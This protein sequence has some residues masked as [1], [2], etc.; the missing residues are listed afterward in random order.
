M[1]IIN[2][3]LIMKLKNAYL[4]FIQTRNEIAEV[5]TKELSINFETALD[6]IE[7]V[8]DEESFLWTQEEKNKTIEKAS[9][10]V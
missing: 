3:L 7:R 4:P 2:P 10:N 1:R 9:T 8:I 6:L 5:L